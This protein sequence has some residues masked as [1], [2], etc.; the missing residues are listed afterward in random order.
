MGSTLK[1]GDVAILFEAGP[2]YEAYLPV[3]VI[4]IGAIATIVRDRLGGG[5]RIVPTLMLTP[6]TAESVVA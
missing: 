3:R 4:S 5:P 2:G 6:T 1:N